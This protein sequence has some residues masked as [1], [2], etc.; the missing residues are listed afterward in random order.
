[1]PFG[2]DGSG[3]F[4]AG[5]AVGKRGKAE[6]PDPAGQVALGLPILGHSPAGIAL[7]RGGLTILAF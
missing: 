6:R 3:H 2:L 4:P 7:Q 1:M 5:I